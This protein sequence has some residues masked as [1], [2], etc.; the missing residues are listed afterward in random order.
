MI[1]TF[2]N[3]WTILLLTTVLTVALAG[4]AAAQGPKWV[5]AF[6]IKGKIGLKWLAFEGATEYKISRK[7]GSGSFEDITTTDKTQYFDTN[8]TAGET[9][10]YKIIAVDAA[11]AE[12]HSVEKSVRVPAS[13]ASA[14]KPP[15]WSGIRQDLRSLLLNWDRVPGGIAYNVMRSTTEG[16]P[17][18]LVGN[19]SVGKYIDRDVEGGT[20]YYYVVTAMN[21]E[22]EETGYSEERGMRF[23]LSAEERAAQAQVEEIV[24][25]PL[26]LTF[27]F[28]LTEAESG[29][30]LAMPADVAVNS[31]GDI[32]VTDTKNMRVV[33]YD[34]SG[35]HKFNF[36][37]ATARGLRDNPPEG[38]FQQPMPLFIDKQDMVYVGDNGNHNIQV[39][40]ADGGFDHQINVDCGDKF[41]P[42]RPNGFHVFDDG[43]IVSSDAGNHRIV[44][45]DPDGKIT[46]DTPGGKDS[47]GTSIAMSFPCGVAVAGDGVISVVDQ[48]GARVIQFDAD[49]NYQGYFGGVGRGY[50]QFGRPKGITLAPDGRIWVT[51]G[52]A[53]TVQVF[54]PEGEVKSAIAGTIEEGV[55]L[56]AP[57]GLVV[58]ADRLY[59][60]ARSVNSVLVFK[61][62]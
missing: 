59:V 13:R 8:I 7:I 30:A 11:G 41:K 32:Y 38:T 50:G 51:D 43:R 25:D 29:S 44:F 24:L 48:M 60:V 27:L 4:A 2:G 28:A 54:S 19:V 52:M 35:K 61:I 57:R 20:H 9:H 36:G 46:L 15:E 14:F 39:Y 1:R 53:N 34:A 5:G 33:C 17:Y 6:F 16:G 49:G 12:T 3:K 10:V 21:E 47:E 18:E 58:S 40:K 31:K 45:L 23:G 42:F 22:F 56:G 55:H 62:S 37:Q 26:N